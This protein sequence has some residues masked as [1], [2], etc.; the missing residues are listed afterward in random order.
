MSRL[1]QIIESVEANEPVQ[2]VLIDYLDSYEDVGEVISGL[3]CRIG[4]QEED[5]RAM[6][7]IESLI[8][9]YLNA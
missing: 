4:S 7:F 1:D 5:E 3:L 9:V 6:Q 8:G 2:D